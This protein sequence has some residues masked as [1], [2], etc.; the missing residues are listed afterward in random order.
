MK[1]NLLKNTLIKPINKAYKGCFIKKSNHQV[2]GPNKARKRA[3]AG[4]NSPRSS[5]ISPSPL[6]LFFYARRVKAFF[7]LCLDRRFLMVSLFE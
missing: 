1:L 7:A 5:E 2:Y 3:F 4:Q 6:G